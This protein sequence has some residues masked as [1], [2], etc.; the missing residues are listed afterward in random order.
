MKSIFKF[1]VE[2]LTYNYDDI[3]VMTPTIDLFPYKKSNKYYPG[4]VTLFNENCRIFYNKSK[5]DY[6]LNKMC[7]INNWFERKVRL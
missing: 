2:F 3:I 7:N 4:L 1:K 5:G 6:I